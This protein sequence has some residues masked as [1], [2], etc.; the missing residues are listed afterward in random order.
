MSIKRRDRYELK[1][2]IPRSQSQQIVEDL[3]HYTSPDTNGDDSGQYI[4]TSLYYDTADYQ[5][6]WDKI[7]GHK[8][9]RKV[10]TRVYNTQ[11]VTPF[12]PCYVEI[13]Q[14]VSQSVQKRRLILPY[15]EAAALCGA[16]AMMDMTNRSEEERA[17]IEEIGYLHT[18]LNLREACVVN[19]K[20]MAM[21]TQN[22]DSGLRVTFDTDLT[23]RSHDLTLLSSHFASNH[24]FLPPDVCIMEIK[25]TGKAPYWL[26]QLIASHR[27]TLRRVS[28]Y[29]TALEACQ[30][31]L[32]RKELVL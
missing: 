30:M 25:T 14:R 31:P 10:R 15:F 11:V 16:G 32:H 13:K 17:I 21:T 8:Y 7:N 27:C 3:A 18:I 28:K 24:F 1:Y 26:S 23:C 22:Y 2:V 4:V 12:T 9:R 19:Y 29:C 6:Y 20:R 5:S